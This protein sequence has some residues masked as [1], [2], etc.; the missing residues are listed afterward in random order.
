MSKWFLLARWGTGLAIRA[1]TA[2]VR[3]ATNVVEVMVSD[4][5]NYSLEQSGSESLASK[6]TRQKVFVGGRAG[7]QTQ[8]GSVVSGWIISGFVS[9]RT[10][11]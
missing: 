1:C 9:L 4:R 2:R 5:R 8:E 6:S 10:S 11:L 3:V 7:P